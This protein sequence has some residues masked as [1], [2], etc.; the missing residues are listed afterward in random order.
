MPIQKIGWTQ[1]LMPSSHAKYFPVLSPPAD[2]LKCVS[3][4]A[5]RQTHTN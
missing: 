4:I 5:I 1:N 2:M 3:A